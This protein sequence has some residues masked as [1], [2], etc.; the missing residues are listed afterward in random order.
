MS[1]WEVNSLTG[2]VCV[3]YWKGEDGVTYCKGYGGDL[4]EMGGGRG[5]LL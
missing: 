1:V 5:V 2:G 3:T 4:P